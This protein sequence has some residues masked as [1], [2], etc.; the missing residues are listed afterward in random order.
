MAGDDETLP[1]AMNAIDVTALIESVHTDREL[2]DQ[3]R[4]SA[5]SMRLVRIIGKVV[6]LSS[7]NFNFNLQD[8][9]PKFTEMYKQIKERD[10]QILDLET[11]LNEMHRQAVD[12]QVRPNSF[13]FQ[14]AQGLI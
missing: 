4:P 6:Q 14:F 2:R 12:M 11:K 3:T 13:I 9:H 10:H 7:C 1:D 5:M 8:N